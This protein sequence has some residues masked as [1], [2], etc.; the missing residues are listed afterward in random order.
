MKTLEELFEFIY[1]ILPNTI[2]YNA[3]EDNFFQKLTSSN[4]DNTSPYNLTF[5]VT[6]KHLVVTYACPDDWDFEEF[7]VILK[8]DGE[9]KIN[10]DFSNITY[11]ITKAS[12]CEKFNEHFN[13]R[14][15]D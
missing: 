14:I 8:K 2:Y 13:F 12:L 9:Y 4:D 10:G 6:Q 11:E 5:N 1:N 7:L 15:V 3:E